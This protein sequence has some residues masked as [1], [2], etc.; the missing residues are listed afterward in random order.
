[1]FLF[2]FFGGIFGGICLLLIV[3]EYKGFWGFGGGMGFFGGNW[4]GV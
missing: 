1:M 3:E 4:F 2:L